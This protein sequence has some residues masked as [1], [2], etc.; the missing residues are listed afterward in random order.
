M[1]EGKIIGPDSKGEQAP[2]LDYRRPFLTQSELP[3][4]IK[5]AF[6]GLEGDEIENF[7]CVCKDR[8]HRV[9]KEG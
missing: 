8:L 4:H 3:S 7:L 6:K 9:V 1:C 5:A 2:G